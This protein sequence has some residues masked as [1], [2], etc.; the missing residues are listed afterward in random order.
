MCDVVAV[1]RQRFGGDDEAMAVLQVEC[2]AAEARSAQHV[3]V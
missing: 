2:D 1:F 3:A